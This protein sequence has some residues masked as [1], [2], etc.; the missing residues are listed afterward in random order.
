MSYCANPE[1]GDR[2]RFHVGF[3]G[4]CSAVY[5]GLR[6]SRA[7]R[8]LN[9]RSSIGRPQ[10]PAKGGEAGE[11]TE[12]AVRVKFFEDKDFEPP[13][14]SL[15]IIEVRNR[16]RTLQDRVSE[17]TVVVSCCGS[18]RVCLKICD[19]GKARIFGRK[20]KCS[21]QYSGDEVD[22]STARDTTADVTGGSV[23]RIE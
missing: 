15:E 5:S 7:L 12:V 17:A 14:G 13:Q 19:L 16:T 10:D 4:R 9:D 2:I 1:E 22:K 23:P 11:T 6:A 21:H 8:Q 3:V 18:T 20:Q